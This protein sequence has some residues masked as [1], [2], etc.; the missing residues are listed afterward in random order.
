MRLSLT[1]RKYVVFSSEADDEHDNPLYPDVS[2]TDPV[3][4]FPSTAMKSRILA[5]ADQTKTNESI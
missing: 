1:V 2:V 3:Q 4:T 5:S